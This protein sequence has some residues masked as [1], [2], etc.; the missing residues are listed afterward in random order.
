M[1]LV[2]YQQMAEFSEIRLR[3]TLPSKNI[4]ESAENRDYLLAEGLIGRTLQ[5]CKY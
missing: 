3:P 5:A 2:R 1:G 4:S